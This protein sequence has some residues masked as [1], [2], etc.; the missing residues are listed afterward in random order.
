M[1]HPTY[2]LAALVTVML[3]IGACGGGGSS[4]SSGYVSSI[5]TPIHA[6]GAALFIVE[7]DGFLAAGTSARVRFT[8]TAGTP[9]AGDTSATAT[10]DAR[11]L[12]STKAVGVA[13]HGS[14]ATASVEL[15]LV[16]GTIIT[17]SSAIAVFTEP[18]VRR[19]GPEDD[20]LVGTPGIDTLDGGPGDDVLFGRGGD[21]VLLGGS[22]EDAL[23][24]EDGHDTMTGDSGS[25]AFLIDPTADAFN[26]VITDY[27]LVEDMLLL[28]G[29]PPTLACL[30]AFASVTD[31]G[32]GGDVVVT[33]SGGGTLTLEGLGTGAIEDLGDLLA[34][35]I[36][37]LIYQMP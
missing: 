2:R 25:D 20:T 23:A 37:V 28:D 35:G 30:D 11:V 12:S 29:V 36:R 4:G 9:F 10:V 33:W 13:P 3:A 16:N 24:G 26:D 8:A 32:I 1:E 6:L 14:N 21:D 19:L 15:L 34:T 5:T 27:R 17:S 31:T 22:G 18:L 7:G